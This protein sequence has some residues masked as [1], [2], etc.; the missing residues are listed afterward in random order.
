MSPAAEAEDAAESKPAAAAAEEE[1]AAEEAAPEPESGKAAKAV[2][3][4][5]KSLRDCMGAQ[6]CIRD[7]RQ[8]HYKRPSCICSD[9][10][11][12]SPVPMQMGLWA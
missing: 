8:L 3:G 6:R 12:R 9:W 7:L 5:F 1:A 10:P 11:V 2:D 4:R